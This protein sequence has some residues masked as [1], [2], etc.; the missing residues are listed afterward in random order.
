MAGRRAAEH[1]QKLSADRPARTTEFLAGTATELFRAT[2]PA[3]RVQ[4][5]FGLFRAYGSVSLPL[6]SEG[7]GLG[8]PGAGAGHRVAAELLA[9]VVGGQQDPLRLPLQILGR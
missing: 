4:W 2:G 9:Q 8:L 7:R 1:R 6:V 5:S 3:D